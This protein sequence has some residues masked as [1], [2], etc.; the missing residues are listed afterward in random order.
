MGRGR[1]GLVSGP[2]LPLK[3]GPII[4][5]TTAPIRGGKI[6]LSFDCGHEAAGPRH[7]KAQSGQNLYTLLYLGYGH[8]AE[9]EQQACR[10]GLA[11]GAGSAERKQ[12]DSLVRGALNDCGFTRILFAQ[13]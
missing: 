13:E 8:A 4:L 2:L 5:S 12:I 1:H 11:C 9:T 10:D 7:S 6:L 3:S